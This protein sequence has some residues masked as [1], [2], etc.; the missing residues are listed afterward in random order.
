MGKTQFPHRVSNPPPS[1]FPLLVISS[2][3]FRLEWTQST[4]TSAIFWPCMID[5]GGDDDDDDCGATDV[6]ND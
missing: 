1:G 3:I 4:Y 2:F 5:D 6:L